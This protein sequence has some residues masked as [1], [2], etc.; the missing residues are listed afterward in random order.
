MKKLSLCERP[1]YADGI[2]RIAKTL[3]SLKLICRKIHYI[4][5]PEYYGPI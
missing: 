4:I 2:Q 3:V 5:K 1:L